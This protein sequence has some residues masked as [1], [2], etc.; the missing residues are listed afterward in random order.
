MDVSFWTIDQRMRLP[1][2]FFGNRQLIGCQVYCLNALAYYYSISE[3]ALPNPACIWAFHFW[4]RTPASVDATFRIGLRATVP[5]NEGEMDTAMEIFP[6]IG[7]PSVGPNKLRLSFRY[8][9]P[10]VL[11][12]RQGMVTGGLKFVGRFYSSIADVYAFFVLEVS[13][14]PKKIPA[15]PGAW[16]AE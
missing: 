12:D 1:D 2:H 3:V 5:T 14:L 13:E 9:T 7:E 15:W 4:V 8:S 6:Y 16:P 10:V 11:T